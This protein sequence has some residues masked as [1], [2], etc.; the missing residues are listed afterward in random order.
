[1]KT[2][3]PPDV[4]VGHVHLRV[5]DLERAV[6]LY[7][8]TLGFDVTAYGPDFGL[9]GA[10]FLLGGR[11]SPPHRPEHVGERGRE[12]LTGRT[13][14][15]AS[16]RPRVSEPPGGGTRCGESSRPRPSRRRGRG[17]RG[18]GLGVFARP[19][20]Q[21]HRTVLRPATRG[22]VRPRRPSD[23]EGRAVRPTRSSGGGALDGRGKPSMKGGHQ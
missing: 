19:G 2:N 16:L 8:G 5:G 4:R 23:S 13:H 9:P 21:R 3:L 7:H 17:P 11:L 22:V 10:A 6:A 20:R 18:D 12:S 1:M 15:S 14:G